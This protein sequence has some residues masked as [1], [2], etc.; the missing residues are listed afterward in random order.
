M[1]IQLP[2]IKSDNEETCKHVKQCYFSLIFLDNII[3][4]Q[5]IKC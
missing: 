2:S 4:H 5:K 1:R 3:F